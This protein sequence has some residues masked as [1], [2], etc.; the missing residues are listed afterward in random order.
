MKIGLSSERFNRRQG[1]DVVF[2][3]PKRLYSPLLS[4]ERERIKKVGKALKRLWNILGPGL[5]TGSSDDDPSGIATYSQAGA[6]FGLATLWT[7]LIT[8]PLM[9]AVQQMCAR[10]GLVTSHGLAGVLGRH[11]PKSA[12][13]VMIV[14]SFPAII[15]NIGADIEGMGAVSHLIFPAVPSAWFSVLFTAI[16]LVSLIVLRYRNIASVLKYLCLGLLVYLIIPFISHLDWTRVLKA[17]FIP[18]LHFTKEYVTIL[19]AIFGTTISPYLFFW[20]ATMEVEE[21]KHRRRQLLVNKKVIRDADSDVDY[22]MLFSN[23]VMLFIILSTGTVLFD[24]GIHKIDTVEQA[25]RAFEPLAGRGAYLLFALGVI[26]TGFLAIPVLAGSLS[27]IISETFGWRGGLDEEFHRAKPFYLV[28]S[29][30]LVVGLLIN[31]LGISPIQ[32]L[33]Y[34]AILY[35]VTAPVIIGIVLH[36]AN[37]SRVMGRFTN[38]RWA[39]VLGGATLLLMTVSAIALLYFQFGF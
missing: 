31:Y 26:G 32:A 3:G 37:N 19:V 36:I 25:A 28:L 14:F 9:A 27:Y 5:I 1:F 23:I 29:L 35:G 20:Q 38:G 16:L 12:L 8:L 34:T 11:Y 30:S 4:L 2:G 13:Y 6:G 33:L 7:A 17:A 24:A 39:N 15:L 18:T 10:I 21:K 22:G